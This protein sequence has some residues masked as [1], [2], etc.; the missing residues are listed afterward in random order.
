MSRQQWRARGRMQADRLGF[1]IWITRC[2]NLLTPKVPLPQIVGNLEAEGLMY[3]PDKT[4][5]GNYLPA[6][7]ILIILKYFRLKIEEDGYFEGRGVEV[8]G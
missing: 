3:G 5:N 6:L 2:S 7:T 1:G 4:N 8:G